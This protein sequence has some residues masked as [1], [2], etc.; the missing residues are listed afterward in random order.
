MGY[1]M[2][3]RLIQRTL[4]ESGDLGSGF[5]VLPEDVEIE[6]YPHRYIP[7]GYVSVESVRM[8]VYKSLVAAFDEKGLDDVL[9]GL[10]D[11][12]GGPPVSV[13]NLINE[14]R[15]RLWAARA[16]INS[17]I[18]RGCGVLCSINQPCA[19]SYVLAF[20]NYAEHF[21]NKK[22]IVFHVLPL[23]EKAFSLCIHF[24]KKQDSYS[25]LSHFFNKF[26]AL[27]KNN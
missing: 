9:Y 17:V 15:L 25:L 18:L 19:E 3:T 2:Y 4:H 12:F 6:L 8:S 23:S 7:E 26:N 10:V 20:M 16:G 11:R 21:F 27:E 13:T 22:K 14:S 24:T 1:E 5:L